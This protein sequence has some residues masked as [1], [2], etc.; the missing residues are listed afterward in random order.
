MQGTALDAERGCHTSTENVAS[1]FVRCTPVG[2]KRRDSTAAGRKLCTHARRWASGI[3][4]CCQ[5]RAIPPQACR[6]DE[7]PRQLG[8]TVFG[9]AEA[10]S[11]DSQV[12]SN[13]CGRGAEPFTTLAA[14]IRTHDGHTLTSKP[15]ARELARFSVGGLNLAIAGRAMLP[16]RASRWEHDATHALAAVTHTKL[17][18][19][20]RLC[21][22][23]A[24]KRVD[25]ASSRRDVAMRT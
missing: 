8:N 16:R 18:M 5:T 10:N 21:H 12:V 1:S 7:A 24:R 4:R 19:L 2:E 6:G 9:L 25:E 14:R 11:C 20:R 3:A 13:C 22:R 15:S 17:L 23:L